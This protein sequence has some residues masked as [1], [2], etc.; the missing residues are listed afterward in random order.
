MTTEQI[1]LIPREI[2]FGNPEK[3]SPQISPDGK[4]MSYLAP[5]NNVLNVW[6]GT[7]GKDDF[8]PVTKDTDRGV[9]NYFW[10]QDNKHI[11]Y[12][13][14]ANGNENWR[15]FAID[16]DN[17]EIRD[18]TPFEDVQTNIISHDKNFPNDLLIALN[19]DN[20]NVHDVYH[21]DLISG[22]LKKIAENPGNF[23]GW[24]V[25]TN[26]KVCGAMEATEDGGF[27]L[28]YRKDDNSEWKNLITWGIEDSLN[29]GVV[30]VSKDGK[31]LY[32]HDSRNFNTGRLV[33]Y[34]IETGKTEVIVQ[35][36]TYDV[37]NV[38]IHPDT[39]EIQMV[40]FV[41]ARNE[42]VILDE[43]IR[44]DIYKIEGI[45][46]GD[47]YIYD[48]DHSDNIWLVGFT[49]DN[50]PVSFY[51]Y[52]RTTKE[53]TFLF[54]TKPILKEYELAEMEAFSIHARD[55]LMIHGYISYPPGKEKNNLPMVINVHGGPWHR[56][57]WGYNSEAQWI[58]NRGYICLQ[59]N[60]RGSTGYGKN[61]LNAGDR[62]WGAKM[63]DDLLDAMDYV[64]GKGH[65]DPKRVAIYG[66]SYGG[67]AALVGATFTP[68]VFTCAIDVV[69]PSSI[70]TLIKTIPPY[71][72]TFLNNFKKRVG[73]PDTEE[74][75]LKSRSPLFKVDNIKVPVM[76]VQGANDPRVKQSEAEQIVEAMKKKG[77]DYDYMLF[78]MKDT[79]L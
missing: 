62:E 48:R 78:R 9:T 66:G 29:S 56:D 52:N 54:Y 47:F 70:I 50:G 10:A 28:L 60:F 26:L 32:M 65:A 16:L 49:A 44:D 53:A 35:D 19:K 12:L 22:E 58:T 38:M 75:F 61:F 24:V 15:L 64:V 8:K 33:S 21:L 57:T 7:I 30:S 45:T 79:V 74:E 63:H 6:V 25:D 42:N 40:S 71:W 67:Y 34:E 23:A 20:P 3:T 72:S 69:G 1:K 13:Q 4:R 18:F 5:V 46:H 36:D 68:D 55:G 59:V 11:L 73:D 2:L 31:Y 39:Y 76:V 14:D 17:G 37:S 77:L 43:S 27:N 51:S 41:K